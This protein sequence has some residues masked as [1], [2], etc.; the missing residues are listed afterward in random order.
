[1]AKV[2]MSILTPL[3]EELWVPF[4]VGSFRSK[5]TR[6]SYSRNWGCFFHLAMGLNA[7]KFEYICPLAIAL[8]MKPKHE[9]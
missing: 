8:D 3:D 5:E 2:S 7:Y 1:M 4:N 9:S 6:I